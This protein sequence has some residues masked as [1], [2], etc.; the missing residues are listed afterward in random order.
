MRSVTELYTVLCE[1]VRLHNKALGEQKKSVSVKVSTIWNYIVTGET[2]SK[3]L[4]KLHEK[5][6]EVEQVIQVCMR[7]RKMLH[8]EDDAPSMDEWLIEA[9]TYQLKEIRGFAEYISKYRKA[10]ELACQT[11]FNN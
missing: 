9:G 2:N 4:L 10:V 7:F 11:T 6:P 3:R 5:C 8:D 1:E